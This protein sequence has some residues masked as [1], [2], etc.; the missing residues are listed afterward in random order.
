M[1]EFGWSRLTYED[2]ALILRGIES[3]E[4]FTPPRAIQIDWSDRC[5]SRCIYCGR[6]HV[7]RDDELDLRVPER[8]FS[9]L[10]DVGVRALQ[11]GGGGEPLFHREIA[12]VLDQ[13]S[14]RSFTISTLATK[15]VLMSKD[16][17]R[18]SPAGGHRKRRDLPGRPHG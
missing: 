12:A 3:A 11:M 8:L 4:V 2:K 9:E 16:I 7:R 13:V 5:N 14:R 6:K 15:G 17:A 10:D 1:C 18:I